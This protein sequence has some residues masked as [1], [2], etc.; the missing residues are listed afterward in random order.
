[1][2]RFSVSWRTTYLRL[3]FWPPEGGSQWAVGKLTWGSNSGLQEEVISELAD[4]LPEA[5]ILASRKRLSVSW[6]TTY[7]KLQLWPPGRGYQWAGGQ[8]TWSYNS[9][10]QEEV[11][12]ELADNLPEAT[13]L[14]S[15]KRL[16]VSWRTTYLKMHFW[17]PGRGYQWAG[18]QLTWGCNSGLQKEVLLELK[19]HNTAEHV[20]S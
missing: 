3:Q 4:N 16:S 17:P 6:R 1:M 19:D 8:L 13:I 5:T 7:L 11:I 9:G 2:R 14:A 15:R 18:G 20:C 12:C 10:L